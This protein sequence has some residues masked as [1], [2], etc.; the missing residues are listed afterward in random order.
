VKV[1]NYFVEGHVNS[2]QLVVTER[3]ISSIF[4]GDLDIEHY[5]AFFS[6]KEKRLGIFYDVCFYSQT[7]VNA[8]HLGHCLMHMV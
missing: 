3:N 7:L 5:D 1:S 6:V 8:F 4:S 2:H